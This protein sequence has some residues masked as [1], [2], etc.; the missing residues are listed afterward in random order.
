MRVSASALLLAA[1]A[2]AAPPPAPMATP[3]T[4]SCTQKSSHAREWHVKDFEFYASYIFTTPA[5]QNSWGHVNFT[6]E[7]PALN[8]VSQCEGSSNQLTD[9]FYGN[10]A[11]NCAQKLPSADTSFTFSR[12]TG[13]LVINQSWACVSEGSRFWAGGSANLT[14]N[15]KDETWQNPEWKMGQTYSSRTI[16]CD[17]L[18]T[19]VQVS[20]MAGIA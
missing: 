8:F 19:D 3:E 15:C 10:F 4:H 17:H 11:Y 13:E 9:F 5:H 6:L 16:T 2:L 18:H 20:S 1:A 7:N 12:P 14:L